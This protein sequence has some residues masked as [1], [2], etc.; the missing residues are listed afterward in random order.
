MELSWINKVRIGA[1]IALGVLIIGVF[2]WPLA[3]PDD[4][5]SPVRPGNVGFIGSLGLLALS[6]AVGVVGFFIAW[7]HGREIGILAV[8][9][10]LATWAVRCGPMRSLTQADA[11]VQA[12]QEIVQSLQFEPLY[13]LL[14]VA[15]GFVGVLVAQCVSSRTSSAI[16]FTRLQN[17]FKPNGIVIGLLAL[18]VAV[19]ASCFF[20]GVIARDLPTSA[21]WP[22][23]QPPKGQIAFAGVMAFA[24]TGFLVKKFFDLS[25]VWTVLATAFVIPFATIA[26]YRSDTIQRFA[27]TEPATFFPHAVFAVLPVQLVAFGAIGSVAGY[28]LALLYD[29]WREHGAAG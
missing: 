2:A 11:T 28:W 8:P 16:N 6:F 12:R 13:W 5:L 7:P 18:L 3:A 9:F 4:P 24:A 17:C 21:K 23:A 27:E 19:L 29:D 20:V 1:V 25:Y 15:V 10:G 26:Y 22:A 14:I